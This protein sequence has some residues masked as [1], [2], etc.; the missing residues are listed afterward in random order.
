[1]ADVAHPGPRSATGA[2]RHAR[3][4]EGPE[5][6]ISGRRRARGSLRAAALADGP[7]GNPP[8]AAE[9]DA[10]SL[11]DS[12]AARARLARRGRLPALPRRL[13]AGGARRRAPV[14]DRSAG[15]GSR[16]RRRPRLHETVRA[17]HL[18]A[19]APAHGPTLAGIG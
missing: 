10:R 13:R 2:D 7:G 16:P 14:R 9:D 18:A 19:A 3:A 1:A 15:R 8:A 11:A 12:R 4:R 6:E 5:P 17:Q